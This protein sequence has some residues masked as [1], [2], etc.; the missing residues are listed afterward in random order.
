[1][2]N[3]YKEMK[4][5]SNKKKGLISPEDNEKIVE[6]IKAKINPM[7]RKVIVC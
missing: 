7:Q 2:A 3:I 1:M 6:L 4:E 5:V